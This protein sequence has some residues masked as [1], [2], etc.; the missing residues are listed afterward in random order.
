ME[1]FFS[2]LQRMLEKKSRLFWNKWYFLKYT[3]ENI[4]PW[5]LR[6]QIFPTITQLEPEFKLEWEENLQSC[7]KKMMEL[8]CKHY[9]VEL[10]L[11]DGEIEKLYR[12]N[13]AIVTDGLFSTRENELKTNLESYVTE[14]LKTKEKKYIRDKLAYDNKQAY[15]WSP[16]NYRRKKRNNQKRQTKQANSEPSDSDSS[17]SSVSSLQ[18]Q[19]FTRLTRTQDSLNSKHSKENAPTGTVRRTPNLKTPM[20]TRAGA[21]KSSLTGAPTHFEPLSNICT[22]TCAPTTGFCTSVSN[23]NTFPMQQDFR[24]A[25]IFTQTVSDPKR[26]M[27]SDLGNPKPQKAN[28]R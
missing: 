25:P 3:E 22:T 20:V 18:A 10:S 13:S 28:S 4:S 19:E 12:D 23:C 26:T 27:S 5:G 15:N 16:N 6:I 24:P 11:I 17:V 21:N 2:R 7:S 1:R 8:L 9:T 14:V